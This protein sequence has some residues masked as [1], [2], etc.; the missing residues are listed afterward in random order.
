M[1]ARDL[2]RR[3]K[4]L[5]NY[6]IGRPDWRKSL[7]EWMPKQAVCAEVG[8]W[9][10]EFSARILRLTKPRELHLIDPWLYQPQFPGCGY[11]GAAARCQ[12]DMD[13]LC[14]RVM[15]ELGGLPTV[16]IHRNRSA[17]ALAEFP[18]GYFDWIYVDGNH[19]YEHVK[20]DLVSAMRKVRRGGFVT[21][22]DYR[23]GAS[24]GY[25]VRRALHDVIAAT[26]SSAPSG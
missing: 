23:W 3:W 21:G 20:E 12:A 4:R 18:D 19:E 11:G 1:R 7:L 9:K 24:D 22:D 17:P 5:R 10:G 2:R 26:G 6:V 13:R 16:F 25:P 14:D 8:V 15:R